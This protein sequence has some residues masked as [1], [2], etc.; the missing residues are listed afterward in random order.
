M[1][2]DTRRWEIVG[3]DGLELLLKFD[4]PYGR[5]TF[6]SVRELLRAVTAKHGQLSNEEIAASF[7][8]RRAQGRAE[9]LEVRTLTDGHGAF[10]YYECGRTPHFTARIRVS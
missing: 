9:H 5:I 3:M 8:K 2:T 4:V 1:P 6:R 10:S 7:L